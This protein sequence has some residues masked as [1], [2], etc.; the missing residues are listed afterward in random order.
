M[1][2]PKQRIN[3]ILRLLGKLFYRYTLTYFLKTLFRNLVFSPMIMELVRDIWKSRDDA[4]KIAK[5]L[6]Y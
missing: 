6:T 2:K 4:F 1:A 5:P 3:P